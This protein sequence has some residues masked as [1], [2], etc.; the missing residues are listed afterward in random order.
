MG[1]HGRFADVEE[2]S[3]LGVGVAVGDAAEDPDLSWGQRV[4]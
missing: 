2:R 1:L 3:D 4:R